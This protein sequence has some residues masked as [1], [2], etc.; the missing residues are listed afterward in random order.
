MKTLMKVSLKDNAKARE[1]LND[2]TYKMIAPTDGEKN[3]NSQEWLMKHAVK[4]CGELIK[5]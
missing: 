1:L 2:M 4:N 5:S 3:V